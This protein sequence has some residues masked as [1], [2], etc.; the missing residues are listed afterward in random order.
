MKLE[1]R[2][3]KFEDGSRKMEENTNFGLPSSIF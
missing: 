1:V 3:L 2:N